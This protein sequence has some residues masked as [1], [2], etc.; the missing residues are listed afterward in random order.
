MVQDPLISN[1]DWQ[2]ASAQWRAVGMV[3]CLKSVLS[4]FQSCL[5]PD[6]KSRPNSPPQ[7]KT[8]TTPH[9]TA[10]QTIPLP[11]CCGIPWPWRC[12]LRIRKTAVWCWCWTAAGPPTAPC[13]TACPSGT[14]WLAGNYS[15]VHLLLNLPQCTS[16][17][18]PLVSGVLHRHRL[19]LCCPFISHSFSSSTRCPNPND[20]KYLTTLVPVVSSPNVQFPSHYKRFVVKMFTFMNQS[21]RLPT[22]KRVISAR[23]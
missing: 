10:W 22:I 18:C 9:I 2:I 14:S 23:A 3:S 20:H 8:C 17:N 1:S 13:L 21:T 11:R 7:Q 15:T 6:E 5:C 16:W 12:V 19:W 4:V